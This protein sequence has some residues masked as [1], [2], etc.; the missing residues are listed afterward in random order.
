MQGTVEESN[1]NE[2]ESNIDS[3]PVEVLVAEINYLRRENLRLQA[4]A[5]PRA[6]FALNR[7][8][9]D[10]EKILFYTGIQQYTI[11]KA[12]LEF[13]LPSGLTSELGFSPTQVH[14]Y[15]KSRLLPEDQFFLTLMRLRKGFSLEV[16]GDMFNIS[17]SS[18]GRVFLQWINLLYLRLGCLNIWPHRNVLLKEAPQGVQE[19]YPNVIGSMDCTEFF[20]QKPSSLV[21]Q[22]QCYSHYKG[23]TTLK[24]LILT[25][26]NGGIIYSSPLYCGSISD[27]A[28]IKK[29]GILSILEEKVKGGELL[30]GDTIL[31]DKGFNVHDVFSNLELELNIPV[32]RITGTQFTPE[33]VEETRKIA[34]ERIHVER[35]IG[36]L[37]QFQILSHRLPVALLGSIDQIYHVCCWLTNFRFPLR[38]ETGTE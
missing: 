35:A 7:F 23:S 3:Q 17:T 4:L 28:I 18:A 31:A 9:E 26:P 10:D 37:K 8:A 1:N 16:L 22:S 38:N 14:K 33:E 30:P 19:E 6:V 24:S 34:Q 27:K 29:S 5:T 13:V 2:M 15:K 36:R 21:R 12:I 11:L 32:F 25:S 20:I